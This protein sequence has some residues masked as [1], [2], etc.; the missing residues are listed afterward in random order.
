MDK[1]DAPRIDLKAEAAAGV[2]VISIAGSQESV[3]S[4]DRSAD[5]GNDVTTD[6]AA[7]EAYQTED[8]ANDNVDAKEADAN[9]DEVKAVAVAAKSS[10][11]DSKSDD[12]AE[13]EAEEP[14]PQ[15]APDSTEAA[16]D[17]SAESLE[18]AIGSVEESKPSKPL[19]EWVEQRPAR[20]GE[21]RREVVA[22]DEY[23]TL[24]ECYEARDVYL[25][26]RTYEHIQRLVGL[27]YL[28][29]SLPSLAHGDFFVR[30]DGTE[31]HRHIPDPT[32]WQFE[33]SGELVWNDPRLQ[34]L[35]A[36]G[37]SIDYV[38]REIA[39]EEYIET[40]DR[41]FGPMKKLYTLM[42]FSPAV[43]RE[44]RAHW[45]NYERKQRLASVGVG[46]G[47]ILGLIGCAYGLLKIDTW[48]KGY[49]TKRLFIG[50]PAAIIGGT[51][52]L[53]LLVR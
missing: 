49:Y 6:S 37:I 32:Q 9:H 3:S 47:G 40:S 4:T 43:D 2:A 29:T 20:V 35:Q 44:L 24:D 26:L 31:V 45:E 8:A 23:S 48:T 15:P 12:V 51:V 39:K 46:A 36:M 14:K 17:S 11:T 22:T 21:V 28:R 16:Q 18:V 30:S 13:E 5:P 33:H 1:A 34:T 41:S 10:D 50:V 25:L 27:P 42:E 7:V 52:L 53:S 19:P 38:Q